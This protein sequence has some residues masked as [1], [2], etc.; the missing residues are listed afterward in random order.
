MVQRPKEVTQLLIRWSNGHGETLT[1]LTPLV[2][3]ELRRLANHYFRS[4]RRDHTLQP[5]ALVHEGQERRKSS[6]GNSN[7]SGAGETLGQG[8][9]LS[10]PRTR[11]QRAGQLKDNRP[12]QENWLACHMRST[13]PLPYL[14]FANH[15]IRVY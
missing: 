7:Q 6:G 10:P 3:S 9:A 2:Y 5:T 14:S 1:E 15:R 8:T 4:E 13:S 12:S 11:C